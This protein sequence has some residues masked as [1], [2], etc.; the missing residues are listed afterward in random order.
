MRFESS[1]VH[2]TKNVE[3]IIITD[4]HTDIQYLYVKDDIS[5]SGGITPLLDKKENNNK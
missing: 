2:S 5:G 3:C 1:R 4:T